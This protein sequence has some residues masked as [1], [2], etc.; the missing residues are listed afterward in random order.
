MKQTPQTYVTA[1]EINTFLVTLLVFK[2]LL[3]V[4][5][6]TVKSIIILTL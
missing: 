6:T 5:S 3:F 4:L 2:Q 1:I